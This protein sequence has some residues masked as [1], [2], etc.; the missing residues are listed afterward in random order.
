MLNF[1]TQNYFWNSFGCAQ[2]PRGRHLSGPRRP[3]WGLMA[4]ILAF[5]GGVANIVNDY[6]KLFY[7]LYIVRKFFRILKIHT[8]FVICNR[9]LQNIAYCPIIL[10]IDTDCYTFQRMH[11]QNGYFLYILWFK[12]DIWKLQTWMAGKEEGG[13]TAMI[14]VPVRDY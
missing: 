9:L 8:Y 3:F 14:I 10:H 4:T 13:R 1:N 5:A 7:V 2:K 11:S 6:S 12:D